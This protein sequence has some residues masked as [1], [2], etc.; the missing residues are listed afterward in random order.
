M[1][2]RALHAPSSRAAMLIAAIA[3]LLLAPVAAGQ[4]DAEKDARAIFEAARNALADVDALSMRVIASGSG[5][6]GSDIMPA[7]EAEVEYARAEEPFDG[8][9]MAAKISGAGT[10]SPRDTESQRIGVL[11]LPDHTKWI[12]H[13]RDALVTANEP[14]AEVDQSPSVTAMFHI[15]EIASAEPY[16][17]ELNADSYELGEPETVGGVMCDVVTVEYAEANLNDQNDDGAPGSGGYAQMLSTADRATW[18][19][20][21]S[22]RLPRRIETVQSAQDLLVLRFIR[23]IRDVEINPEGLDLASLE[24]DAPEG[25]ATARAASDTRDGTLRANRDASR[26]RDARQQRARSTGDKRGDTREPAEGSREDTTDERPQAPDFELAKANGEKVTDDTIEGE[27]SLLYFWG[28]WCVPCRTISPLVSDLVEAFEDDPVNIYGVAIR[29]RSADA[30]QSYL[31]EKGYKHTLLLHPGNPGGMK[32]ARAFQV[33]RY[34]TLIVIGPDGGIAHTDFPG[35][36]QSSEDLVAGVEE[37]IREEL[38]RTGD[39]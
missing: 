38:K 29:E 12:D 11:Y 33:R 13:E 32:V 8:F 16:E 20:A 2:P 17:R 22:D 30:P 14:L 4:S 24:I 5:S 18:Y 10:D 23:Q 6:L 27:V 36:D 26:Q 21:Q 19:I 7:G 35:R 3:A 9:A 34:P 1:K 31:E 39:Q 15:A 37:A 25:Y 28:T